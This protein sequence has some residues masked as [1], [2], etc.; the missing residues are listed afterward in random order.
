MSM[1][2]IWHH[3]KGIKPSLSNLL[4]MIIPTS[5]LLLCGLVIRSGF[6]PIATNNF[7]YDQDPAYVYLYSGLTL[8]H[9][10]IPIHVDHPG[11]TF[12]IFFAG[13]IILG[14]LAS[15]VATFTRPG[16][17]WISISQIDSFVVEN[18][19]ALMLATGVIMSCLVA[20]C[21]YLLAN[22]IWKLTGS[23][24]A[25]I[26]SQMF[27]FMWG[28]S[29][30]RSGLIAMRSLYPS[31]EALLI[32]LVLLGLFYL[33]PFYIE[34]LYGLSVSTCKEAKYSSRA[35]GI[36]ASLGIFTKI[37]FAPFLPLLLTI[38]WTKLKSSLIY[39]ACCCSLFLAIIHPRIIHLIKWL[40]RNAIYKDKYGTGDIGII[41]TG[42][43]AAFLKALSL[44]NSY[45]LLQ[46]L[47]AAISLLYLLHY[48]SSARLN[49]KYLSRKTTS[50][51]LVTS[52][53][54]GHS[55]NLDHTP[56]KRVRCPGVSWTLLISSILIGLFLLFKSPHLHYFI[57]TAIIISYLISML[58]GLAEY[59]SHYSR[60]TL[61]VQTNNYCTK[62]ILESPRPAML[63]NLIFASILICISLST[64][65]KYVYSERQKST[66]AYVNDQQLLEDTQNYC[67]YRVASKRCSIAFALSY[68]PQIATGKAFSDI[69]YLNIWGG[70]FYAHGPNLID[71]DALQSTN[72]YNSFIISKKIEKV[73]EGLSDKTKY[74]I[75]SKGG[76]YNIWQK[77]NS[78]YRSNE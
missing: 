63:I 71:H 42:N 67:T 21:T 64:L 68:N 43:M 7:F 46:L 12:Q 57:P 6:Y 41:D 3:Q 25:A 37:T 44:D 32:I 8:L 51:E 28:S 14:F 60:E 24:A 15:K 5:F 19:E 29:S 1:R 23:L 33:S 35:L 31:P 75:I 10:E 30:S 20:I 70:K 76:T 54:S 65:P 26:I 62:F 61:S 9:R 47:V 45:I 4:L 36:I 66:Y 56:N 49:D 48:E 55:K 53:R 78:N 74:H 38:K 77:V 72:Q 50:G 22:R 69:K 17:D 58:V 18:S 52:I 2:K 16:T 73:V 27:L 11:T 40:V 39:F 13:L 34:S 59:Q